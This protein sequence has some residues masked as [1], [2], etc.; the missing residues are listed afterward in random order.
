MSYIL[1]YNNNTL[2]GIYYSFDLS[3]AEHEA[4]PDE[5][6]KAR[7]SYLKDVTQ[8]PQ[9]TTT[10]FGDGTSSSVT[11]T[12]QA[13]RELSQEERR[14]IY[15]AK[16]GSMGT[17]K[18][19]LHN[20][21]VRSNIDGQKEAHRQTQ[22]ER[23]KREMM[24]D[25]AAK[26]QEKRDVYDR[27]KESQTHVLGDTLLGRERLSKKVENEKEEFRK[28]KQERDR[29]AS[30]KERDF[31]AAERARVKQEYE[32]QKNELT[33][34][35]KIEPR[36]QQSSSSSSP[37]PAPKDL[38]TASICFRLPNGDTKESEFSLDASLASARLWLLHNTPEYH[39]SVDLVKLMCPYPRRVCYV[40]L[41]LLN[42]F[43][44]TF[45]AD[46]FEIIIK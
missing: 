10:R 26:E 6:A 34:R 37:C 24:A 15:E 33:K 19:T 22:I 38:S 1:F 46:E 7:Q 2:T 21:E 29:L 13:V 11:A 18:R 42:T 5:V 44:E 16:F 20:E 9:Q 3:T 41:F 8:Q 43:V 35:S 14:A 12:Q 36:P 40:Y 27:M 30:L 32:E 28:A 23:K 31:R 39:D 25:K 45:R 4:T 17:A